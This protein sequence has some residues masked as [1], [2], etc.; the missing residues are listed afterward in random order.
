MIMSSISCRQIRL[1][2]IGTEEQY[3]IDQGKFFASA[4]VLVK[5]WTQRF[6]FQ[7]Y[8]HHHLSKSNSIHLNTEFQ[9]LAAVTGD[10]YV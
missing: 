4:G 9:A 8:N 1:V 5:I 10:K 6:Q 3:S 2:G 7:K